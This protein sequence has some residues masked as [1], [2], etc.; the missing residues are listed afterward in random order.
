MQ[1]YQKHATTLSKNA[2]EKIRDFDKIKKTITHL[3][4][5]TCTGLFA[6]GLDVELMRELELK[7][8]YSAKQRQFH[9]L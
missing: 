9:G 2:I 3:I 6:P 7:P 5:V 1:L 8:S 4:T